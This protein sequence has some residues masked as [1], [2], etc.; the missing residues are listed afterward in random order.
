MGYLHAQLEANG[1]VGG[2]DSAGKQRGAG[3]Q[4]REAGQDPV[5]CVCVC[6]CVR[7]CVRARV[8]VI[9]EM[10]VLFAIFAGSPGPLAGHDITG[11]RRMRAIPTAQQSWL[12]FSGGQHASQKHR[13]RLILEIAAG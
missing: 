7:V 13:C 1:V 8:A 4:L 12:V 3:G 5:L 9:T 6:A 11:R 2:G 10:Q